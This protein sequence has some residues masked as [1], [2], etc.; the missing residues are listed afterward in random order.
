MARTYRP[1]MPRPTMDD[2]PNS[3]ARGYGSDWRAL[4]AKQPRT[5]CVDCRRPWHRSFN[6]DHVKPRSQGGTDDP[7]NLEWRCPG[8]HSRKTDRFD[9][10]FGRPIRAPEPAKTPDVAPQHDRGGGGVKS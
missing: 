1:L 5:P 4:R 7:A 10:G 2:R 8:C 6:L 3:A 9:G